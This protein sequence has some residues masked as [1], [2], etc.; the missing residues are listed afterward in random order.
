MRFFIDELEVFFPYDYLYKEQYDY[1]YRLK[2]AISEKGKLNWVA[3][4]IFITHLQ[5]HVHERNS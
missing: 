1:M 4:F 3:L 2:V 5:C